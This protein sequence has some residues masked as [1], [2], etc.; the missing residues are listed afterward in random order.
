MREP[1]NDKTLCRPLFLSNATGGIENV[2]LFQ[3]FSQRLYN[4]GISH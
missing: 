3:L 1:F 2:E 4:N